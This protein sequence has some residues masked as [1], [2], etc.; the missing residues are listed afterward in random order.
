MFW[1]G[2]I[3]PC[4]DQDKSPAEN[5]NAC[6]RI[7]LRYLVIKFPLALPVI[8]MLLFTRILIVTLSCSK[9][10]WGNLKNCSDPYQGKPKLCLKGNEEYSPPFP[11]DVNIGINLREIVDIDK[12]KKSITARL[13]LST[14]WTDPR[15]GLTETSIG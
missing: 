3:T 13:G 7:Y 15:L 1:F 9:P 8:E 14:Y 6:S 5:L 2:R 10:I 12:N 11:V 4:I